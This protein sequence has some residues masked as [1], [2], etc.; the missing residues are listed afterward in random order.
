MKIFMLILL[1]PLFSFAS[2][3]IAFIELRTQNGQLIQLEP[4]GQFVHIA[5]SYQGGWLHSHPYRGVE[6]ISQD[7]LE[8]IGTIK[9]IITI[10]ELD[11]L[12]RNQVEKYLGKPSDPEFSWRDDKIYCSELVAKLLNID[13]Q[14]MTFETAIWPDRFQSLKGQLGLSPDDLFQ[15]L[16]KNGYQ[17]SL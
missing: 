1:M 2:I 16:V 4:N 3:D 13:P 15:L 11:S 5:I 7:I 9:S 17:K 8:K 12:K 10:S 14:P 6:V